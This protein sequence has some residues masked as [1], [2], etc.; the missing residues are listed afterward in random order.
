MR[1]PQTHA[2]VLSR[3]EVAVWNAALS[4]PTGSPRRARLLA[5]QSQIRCKRGAHLRDTG[6]TYFTWVATPHW[7]YTQR[8]IDTEEEA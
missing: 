5:L 6:W 1:D 3:R 8:I 4:L 7:Q 2:K